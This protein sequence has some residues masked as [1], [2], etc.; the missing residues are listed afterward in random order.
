MEAWCP[1]GG[2]GGHLLEDRTLIEIAEKYNKT[3]AQIVIRWHLQRGIILFPKSS[4]R[5]RMLSNRNVFDF[6]LTEKDMEEIDCLNK[7]KRIGANPDNF[8]F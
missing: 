1:L 5:E 7:N 4:H 8:N 2:S 3:V 6:I